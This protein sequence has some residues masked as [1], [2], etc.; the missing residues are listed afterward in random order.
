ME[1]SV[2]YQI[3]SGKKTVCFCSVVRQLSAVQETMWLQA[4]GYEENI[5]L[6]LTVSLFFQTN[7]D[8][9]MILY[10]W[11]RNMIYTFLT[12]LTIIQKSKVTV[13][14]FKMLQKIFQ[15]LLF[16]TFY[17]SKTTLFSTLIIHFYWAANQHIRM[18]S[19]GSS[20]IEAWSNDAENSASPS[21]E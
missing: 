12:A 3:S 8:A 6:S 15:M 16:W 19:E 7:T 17:S 2:L 1:T 11:C 5:S 9:N 20:D 13:K 10:L 21:Q 18:I 4:Q 14:I